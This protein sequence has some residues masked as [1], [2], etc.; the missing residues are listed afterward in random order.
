ML[1]AS[2]CRVVVIVGLVAELAAQALMAPTSAGVAT[3]ELPA[4][5]AVPL[6]VASCRLQQGLAAA[7]CSQTSL[8]ASRVALR[9]DG[10]TGGAAR[11]HAVQRVVVRLGTTGVPVDRLGSQFDTNLTQP[12]ATGFDGA[13][14]F[15]TDGRAVAGPESFLGGFVVMLSQAVPIGIAATDTLLL[16]VATFGNANL[17]DPAELDA[18]VDPANALGLGSVTR[19]GNACP[20]GQ[21]LPGAALDITGVFEPGG[22]FTIRGTGYL[23]NAPVVSVLTATLLPQPLAFPN[24]TPSC[25]IYVEPTTV[26]GTLS[27]AADGSGG[28]D[29]GRTGT[30]PLPKRPGMSGATIY[31]QNVSLATPWAGNSSGLA[32]SNYRT[33]TVGSMKNSALRGWVAHHDR[34]ASAPV[35]TTAYYGALA[36]QI[37]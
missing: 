11:A 7:E 13:L 15:T 3:T 35:A 20:I 18:L 37:D 4:S 32:T 27:F 19:H 5:S 21:G 12:L 29:G 14:N 1:I 26:F 23:P 25:W 6:M 30:L 36:L 16:D 9:Y 33:I 28:L 2:S 17:A 31:V 34:D 22:S 8:L 10:P 24:T